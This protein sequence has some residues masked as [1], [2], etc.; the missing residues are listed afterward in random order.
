MGAD[1]I[2]LLQELVKDG[3]IPLL[4]QHA[5]SADPD[6]QTMSLWALKHLANS[7][8]NEVKMKVLDELGAGWLIQTMSAEIRDPTAV[9]LKGTPSQSSTPIGMGTPNAAGERVDLLNA[10]EEVAMDIDTSSSDEEADDEEMND[11]ITSLNLPRYLPHTTQTTPRPL[12]AQ[13][14]ARLKLI[15]RDEQDPTILTWKNEVRIQEQALDFLRNLIGDPQS[16]QHTMVENI[17]STFESSRLF[18]ILLTKIRP[19]AP[20]QPERRLPQPHG[21]H[22]VLTTPGARFPNHTSSPLASPYSSTSLRGQSPQPSILTPPDI[23]L[24][25]LFILVHIANGRAQQRA[26]L[27]SQTALIHATLPLFTHGDRRIRVACVWLVHN[28]IWLDSNSSEDRYSAEDRA[29]KL[30]EIGV[31][32]RVR[33]ALG[34]ESLDVKERAKGVMDSFERLLGQEGGDMG[35]RSPREGSGLLASGA[36]GAYEGRRTH[37]GRAWER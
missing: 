10:P 36:V 11:S 34:D 5:H 2:R 32:E 6:L 3:C 18:D 9:M 17:L 28:L 16:E 4:C 8:P 20:P 30:R 13:Y 1:S 19:T 37:G 14:K 12:N 35:P 24:S 27:L 25:T 26:L 23:L 21:K 33:S 31:E 29:R 7:A 22:P 15:K